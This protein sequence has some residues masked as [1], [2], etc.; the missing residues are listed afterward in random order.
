MLRRW[1]L[2][3]LILDQITDPHNVGAILRSAAAFAADAVVTTGRHSPQA[4]AVVAEHRACQRGASLAVELLVV[5]DLRKHVETR[6]AT[7]I[8][9]AARV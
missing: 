3:P 6:R 1:G 5:V 9:R 2:E 7:L 8:S 4:R